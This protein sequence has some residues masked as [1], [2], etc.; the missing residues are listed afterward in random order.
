MKFTFWLYLEI[1]LLEL[2]PRLEKIFPNLKIQRD[3]ENVW[4][5]LESFENGFKLNVS[6]SHNWEKG[7]YFDPIKIEIYSENL[8]DEDFY[9]NLFFSEF[10]STIYFG[11]LSHNDLG[12]N[13]ISARILKVYN[14]RL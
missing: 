9:G 1:E 10:D 13:S 8:S 5:W 7:D 4:E 6:R 3:Y 14:T 2:L 12:R 11:E